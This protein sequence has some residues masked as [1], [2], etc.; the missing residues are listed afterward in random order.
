MSRVGKQPIVL[1]DTVF[2]EKRGS[3]VVIK[4]PKGELTVQLPKGIDV[5]N[6]E[7]KLIVSRK[8]GATSALF[9]LA[10]TL[11]NNAVVGATAGFTKTLEIR[12]TGFKA[13]VQGATLVLH[14]GFS[15][16]ITFPTPS[17]IAFEVKASKIVISGIDKQLVGETAAQVRRIKEPDHYKGK[18][19]RYDGEVVKLKPGKA[20]KTAG[21]TTGGAK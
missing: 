14:V 5:V 15:H 18:G 20:A 19:I 7:N 21:T 12:G 9:G 13:A 10:R 2:F 17:G 3:L 1:P 16:T 6:K 8:S 4:G 11:V